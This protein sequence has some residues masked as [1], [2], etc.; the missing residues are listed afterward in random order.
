VECSRR[1]LCSYI[2]FI[3]VSHTKEDREEIS[4]LAFQI[5]NLVLQH[6]PDNDQTIFKFFFALEGMTG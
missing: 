1:I 5:R 6:L 2:Q 3:A 4:L